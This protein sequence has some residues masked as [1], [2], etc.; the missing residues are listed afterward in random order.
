MGPKRPTVLGLRGLQRIQPAHREDDNLD[1][2]SRTGCP[3]AA[4]ADLRWY[5][6]LWNEV[7]HRHD[8]RTTRNSAPRTPEVERR[9]QPRSTA[10]TKLCSR[11]SFSPSIS[12]IAGRTI[13]L[14]GTAMLGLDSDSSEICNQNPGLNAIAFG[15]FKND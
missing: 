14:C 3:P 5:R 13:N 4:R 15:D 9:L 8:R 2:H 12:L 10:L 1:D 11:I 7:D 6:P